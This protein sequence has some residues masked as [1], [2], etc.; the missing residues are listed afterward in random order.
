MSIRNLKKKTIFHA[1]ESILLTSL[2]P[3]LIESGNETTS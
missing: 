1:P 3:R 2:I